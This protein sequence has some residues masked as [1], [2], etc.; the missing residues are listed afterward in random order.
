MDT[1]T[2]YYT[3]KLKNITNTKKEY[4]LNHEDNI[5]KFEFE[6]NNNEIIFKLT[7]ISEISYYNYIRKYNYN[8]IINDLNLS[9]DI[10]NNIEK[11][12]EYLDI[13]EYQI[14]DD[15]RNKKLK[16]NQK[17]EIVLYENKNEDMM[18]IMIE[19]IN[20]IKKICI[21]QED[22][23]KELKK[24]NE[25]KDNQIEELKERINKLIKENEINLIYECSSNGPNFILGKSFVERNKNNIQL[26]INGAYTSLS[27]CQYLQKGENNIKLIIEKKLYDLSCMFYQCS[28]LKNID[29][30]KYLNIEACSNFSHMFEGCSSLKEI[31]SL[32][33]WNVSNGNNFSH[34]FSGCSSLEKI[35]SLEKW[36]VSKGNDFS[37]IF[38]GCSSLKEINKMEC[39]KWK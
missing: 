32:E 17:D 35:N 30:L 22:E 8:E 14:F 2:E 21:K 37:S 38:S 24:S 4:E 10:Y 26:F 16:I 34:M 19:E 27:E 15:N 13:K 33:K 20:K 1:H 31:N 29:G 39:F 18:N 6:A 25:D 12:F 23:I 28:A 7:R 5:Y 3:P 11:I 36:N 9:K